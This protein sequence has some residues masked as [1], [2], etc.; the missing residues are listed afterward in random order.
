MHIIARQDPRNKE[1]VQATVRE[2]L[3]FVNVT[4]NY[5]VLSLGA[6]Y[7]LL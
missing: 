7:Y 2:D 1:Q 5:G 4:F 3:L 6:S